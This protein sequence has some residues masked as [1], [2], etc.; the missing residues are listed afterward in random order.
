MLRCA[1]CVHSRSL[2]AS[3]CCARWPTVSV[4]AASDRHS[5]QGTGQQTTADDRHISHGRRGRRRGKQGRHGSIDAQ[6]TAQ[7]QPSP[8]IHL[9]VE[10][11]SALSARSPGPCR[12]Q[13]SMRQSSSLCARPFEWKSCDARHGLLSARVTGHRCRRHS[14]LDPFDWLADRLKG[15]LAGD[16]PGLPPARMWLIGHANADAAFNCA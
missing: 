15:R 16:A 10:A 12:Q 5:P 8:P 4:S 2:A 1:G 3:L 6:A 14:P 9:S 11:S 13:R 7:R